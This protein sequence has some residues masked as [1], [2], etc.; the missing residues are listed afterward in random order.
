[1]HH[2]IQFIVIIKCSPSITTQGAP[3]SSF[4]VISHLNLFYSSNIL[5]VLQVGYRGKQNVRGQARACIQV[6]NIERQFSAK[7][8]V[9]VVDKKFKRY[10]VY[11][12]NHAS[13]DSV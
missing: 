1:V 8:N 11:A 3:L 7:V 6:L 12:W 5:Y 13:D 9:K 2:R 10:L 4:M